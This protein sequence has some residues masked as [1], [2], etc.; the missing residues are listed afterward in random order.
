MD[1]EFEKLVCF[2]LSFVMIDTEILIIWCKDLSFDP[3]GVHEVVNPELLLGIWDVADEVF[4]FRCHQVEGYSL[5]HIENMG[6]GHG[7]GIN[8]VIISLEDRGQG[9]VI[10]VTNWDSS[11]VGD[12]GQVTGTRVR[13]MIRFSIAVAQSSAGVMLAAFMM[14]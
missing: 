10:N 6:Y 14:S 2:H 3:D 8:D 12:R 9:W 4:W 11:A 7:P 13:T 1:E 5:V